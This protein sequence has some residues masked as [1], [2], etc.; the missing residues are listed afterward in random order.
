MRLPESWREATRRRDGAEP[1]AMLAIPLV[2][3]GELVGVLEAVRRPGRAGLHRPERQ[4]FAG[5][6]SQ[7][8]RRR[9]PVR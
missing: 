5:W 8:G 7:V 3:A 2:R 4:R 6:G 1:G 9:W